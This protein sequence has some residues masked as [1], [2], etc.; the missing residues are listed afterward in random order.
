MA[1]SS[2]PSRDNV[3]AYRE[4]LRQQGLRPIENWV[5]DVRSPAFK[6]E[7]HRQLLAVAQSPHADEDQAFIDRPISDFN[8]ADPVF[9][10]SFRDPIYS[11]KL[12]AA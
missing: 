6:A 3:R 11:R 10:L 12:C 1:T 2:G 7:V 5:A 8:C 4:H 9:A